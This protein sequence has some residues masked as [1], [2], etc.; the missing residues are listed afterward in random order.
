MVSAAQ[1]RY[2][3]RYT[4][5]A[6]YLD[7]A[8]TTRV[9]PEVAEVVAACMREDYGNPSSAHF[10]GDRA[11]AR[12]E[13]AR[14]QLSDALGDGGSAD[15]ASGR[16]GALI[17]TSGGTESDVLGVVGAARANASR[18]RQ[19]LYSALEH[20]AVSQ[21]AAALR[22]EGFR[23]QAVPANPRGVVDVESILERM[24]DDTIVVAVM[25]VQ[26]ELGTIQPV[27][28]IARA[29]H[30]TWP[31]V[32]IHCDA[33]QALGKLPLDVAALGV[34]SVAVA[35]HK[36]HG[37]KGVG[38]LWLRSGAKLAPLYAGGGQQRGL[39]AGTLNVPGIAG[40]GHAAALAS[41]NLADYSAR[42]QR[43]A[44]T[45][46]TAAR[47]SGRAVQRNGHAAP[48]APHILSLA[49]PGVPAGPLLHVL[50]SR[51]VLVSAGS[52]CA[53][54]DSK[55]SPTLQAIGLSPEVGTLRFSFGRDTT[56]DELDRAAQVLL[57]ALRDL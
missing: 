2:H 28:D 22:G 21:S 42:W 29:I 12:V 51:G 44:D 40:L 32:H 30:S 17:F 39:R 37:P 36:L 1:T 45:L 53:A 3:Q 11:A 46:L 38:A 16:H 52:A 25:L 48:C 13:A 19:V 14:A 10:H 35:A 20:P 9:A 27:A 4:M 41:P 31:D 8:A 56:A 24:S 26:N 18:G 47:D 55:P 49:F 33:V 50:E 34:D 7:N 23:P 57:D 5:D 6:I 43:F 15:D 54:R